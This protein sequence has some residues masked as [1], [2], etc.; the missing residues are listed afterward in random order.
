[1]ETVVHGRGPFRL[2]PQVDERAGQGHDDEDGGV[3]PCEEQRHHH[4][5]AV[6]L[7]VPR[8]APRRVQDEPDLVEPSALRVVMKGGCNIV[9]KGFVVVRLSVLRLK[10]GIYK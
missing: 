2:H 1:M 3:V 6:V 5:L 10:S 9:K 8:R 4:H 7:L